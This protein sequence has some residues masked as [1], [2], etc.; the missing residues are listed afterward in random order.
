MFGEECPQIDEVF[1]TS[2]DAVELEADDEVDLLG[3]DIAFESLKF[4]TVLVPRTLALVDVELKGCDVPVLASRTE[5]DLLFD[6]VLLGNET[7]P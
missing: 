5:L 6:F 7:G 3:C 4:R 1:E 2:C